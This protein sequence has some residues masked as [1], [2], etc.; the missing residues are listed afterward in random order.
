MIRIILF[1]QGC[2]LPKVDMVKKRKESRITVK[3][4][5][6]IVKEE[7]RQSPKWKPNLFRYF[8]QLHPIY[9]RIIMFPSIP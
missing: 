3:S 8:Y 9:M 6:A 1:F 7:R 4:G 5:S 2:N